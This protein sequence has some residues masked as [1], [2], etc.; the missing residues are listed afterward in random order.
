MKFRNIGDVLLT[1]PL[2]SNLK[3]HYPNATI[4]FALNRGTEA[5]IKENPNVNKL[6]IC[7][8]N[9]INKSSKFKQSLMEL[10]FT[11]NIKKQ[12]Y[13]I[14]INLTTGDRGI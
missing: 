10:E 14:A 2:L 1:T 7:D 11:K 5:M 3:A 12:N 9:V 4:D 6:H 8:R 13:D